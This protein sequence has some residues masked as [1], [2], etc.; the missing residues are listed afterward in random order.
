MTQILQLQW[1]KQG[2]R[3]INGEIYDT[4]YCLLGNQL[5]HRLGQVVGMVLD[6]A[7]RK[8]AYCIM[9][10]NSRNPIWID[11]VPPTPTTDII[12]EVEEL[13][14]DWFSKAMP[15]CRCEFDTS[16]ITPII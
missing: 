11:A 3:R 10:Q 7:P 4:Y 14:T 6:D 8:R 15:E 5:P 1:Q 2:T 13:L 9:P 16:N 12:K